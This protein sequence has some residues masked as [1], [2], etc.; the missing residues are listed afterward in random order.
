MLE[1]KKIRRYCRFLIT[2]NYR[3]KNLDIL[4][5]FF[6][7]IFCILFTSEVHAQYWDLSCFGEDKK[8]QKKIDASKEVY[9]S[10][11]KN[12]NYTFLIK[13]L[14]EISYC[15]QGLGKGKE[16]VELINNLIDEKI[17][18]DD[19]F[20]FKNITKEN[21]RL[22]I[23]A[24]ANNIKYQTKQEYVKSNWYYQKELMKIF[25]SK[26]EYFDPLF[27]QLFYQNFNNWKDPT[28]ISEY[29]I[30]IKKIINQTV[31]VNSYNNFIKFSN[32]YLKFNLVVNPEE[33]TD[34]YLN[35]YLKNDNIFVP[36][37]IH[38]FSRNIMDGL[39]CISKSGFE[40]YYK[41][42]DKLIKVH[43]N[44]MP[45]IDNLILEAEKIFNYD[46]YKSNPKKV[47]K[48]KKYARINY[49]DGITAIYDL[50]ERKLAALDIIMGA[51]DLKDKELESKKIEKLYNQLNSLYFKEKLIF[52]YL[53]KNL[54]TVDRLLKYEK[55]SEAE[56]LILSSLQSI[57]K[58]TY[59]D[60]I[61]MTYDDL[62]GI[63]E[64]NSDDII[65]DIYK[66]SEE[67][68]KK[69]SEDLINRLKN[70]YLLRYGKILDV[71]GRYAQSIKL[72][73]KL[74]NDLDPERLKK[75]YAITDDN[76]LYSTRD[77]QFKLPSLYY[78]MTSI[79]VKLKDF[80][81]AEIYFKKWGE[82]CTKIESIMCESLIEEQF[83]FYTTTK[84]KKYF[85]KAE[86]SFYKLKKI[87]KNTFDK[88]DHILM[89]LD[90]LNKE[91]QLYL[92]GYDLNI[93]NQGE[94]YSKK[95]CVVVKKIAKIIKENKNIVS[96]EQKLGSV[97]ASLGCIGKVQ[98]ATEKEKEYYF[99]AL[100]N[101]INEYEKDLIK[102]SKFGYLNKVD[103]TT[104]QGFMLGALMSFLMD[105]ELYS[106]QLQKKYE[107]LIEKSFKLIQYEMGNYKIKSQ[108]KLVNKS[109]NDELFKLIKKR[110]KLEFK[111][112]KIIKA[113]FSEQ[114]NSES[115]YLVNKENIENQINKINNKI[116]SNHKNYVMG[117]A[118]KRYNFLDIQK[119]LD[120]NDAF[121][122]VS[123]QK[124]VLVYLITKNNIQVYAYP[125]A[126]KKPFL[127]NDTI[128]GLRDSIASKM[129]D[130]NSDAYL[131]DLDFL[132][133]VV[134]QPL[135]KNL[136]NIKNL[137]I[138][139]DKYFSSLPFEMLIT[140]GQLDENYYLIKNPENNYDFLIKDYNISYFPSIASFVEL[141]KDERKLTSSSS[142]LGIGNP[143]F[144]NKD[145]TLTAK[146]NEIKKISL[147]RGGF[148][149]DSKIIS[150]RFFEIPF[151]E[152][153]L[154]AI[155]LLFK[156]SNLLVGKQAT[157][158]EVKKINLADYDVVSFA[159]HAEVSGVFDNFDEPFIVLSPP[160]IGSEF[161]DGL[162][163]SSEISELNL[164]VNLIVLS[165][166]NTAS[167]E[168]RYAV[169]FSGLINSFFIAGADSIIA[170][171]WPVADEAGYLL[172]SE[173]MKKITSQNKSKAEALKMTKLEFIQ[174]KYGEEYKHPFFWASY[175]LVGN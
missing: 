41:I 89:Q 103:I 113:T 109:K 159:S 12:K 81:T 40:Q 171:H 37:E 150:E 68:I 73:K 90:I 63:Y 133:R 147:N 57:Q 64:A 21:L 136:T 87:N 141:N 46:E 130:L 83:T 8:Y 43:L 62:V 163:T 65:A 173:T 29:N 121:L 170:T 61:K 160:N 105:D 118:I 11:K 143:K 59:Q 34:Y 174:G 31:K 28:F 69:S 55:Y 56:K 24:Y 138:V 77:L 149:T 66:N 85:T 60:V 144:R 134:F 122:F 18:S 167:K 23:Y 13:E 32:I 148:I 74:I 158:S 140:N 152:T 98:E 30:L 119:K 70:N 162:L 33:C 25:I 4:R 99:I 154:N 9:A 26:N 132:Y 175:I 22:L 17:I 50:K 1:A 102:K 101:F 107:Y 169:G 131:N 168:N 80:D 114:N 52:T 108:K 145:E 19:I 3:E 14:S 139:T 48:E 151:T 104:D 91:G 161:D 20:Y 53:N 96:K 94:D 27:Y 67:N 72:K 10:F 7:L 88:G 79:L 110:D 155:S 16:F 165:A 5:L 100:D 125:Q 153:E 75:I 86:D 111:L 106:K 36:E 135:E 38:Y 76:Y 120:K 42:A 127:I 123:N 95:N 47:L 166:C 93:N 15:Y 45:K 146:S 44:V 164:D 172:M 156:N 78:S 112:E 117:N 116:S 97:M 157:E 82:L 124:G 58:L 92:M 137:K 128:Q 35:N 71:T 51:Y 2:A 6:S 115:S 84:Q 142:F 49:T 129:S 54:T 126:S 39:H